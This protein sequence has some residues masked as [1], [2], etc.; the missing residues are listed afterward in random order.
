MIQKHCKK[1]KMLPVAMSEA[2]NLHMLHIST[3]LVTVTSFDCGILQ[4]CG[5]NNE[6]GFLHLLTL[7]ALIGTKVVRD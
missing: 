4:A 7:E 2:A 6:N 1:D 3:F 5:I